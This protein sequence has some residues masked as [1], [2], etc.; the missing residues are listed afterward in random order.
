MGHSLQVSFAAR[1]RA[2]TSWMTGRVVQSMSGSEMA[3]TVQ[4]VFTRLV[5][6]LAERLPCVSTRFRDRKVSEW[7][8]DS[9]FLQLHRE[10]ALLNRA[11]GATNRLNH[12]KIPL[13]DFLTK[14]G[15]IWKV[16]LKTEYCSARSSW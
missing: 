11:E 2:G 15:D 4:T 8:S 9:D 14:K 13:G 5:L 7:T 3:N 6:P 1:H 10:V 16:K 12:S